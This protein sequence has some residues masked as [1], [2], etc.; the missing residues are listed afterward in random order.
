MRKYHI[1]YFFHIQKQI[2]PLWSLFEL[3]YIFYIYKFLL[4]SHPKLGVKENFKDQKLRKAVKKLKGKR[5]RETQTLG[6]CPN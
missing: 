4:G 6:S 1:Y 2:Y 3:V 5:A